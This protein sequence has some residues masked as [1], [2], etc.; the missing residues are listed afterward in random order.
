[1]TT[2][3][4]RLFSAARGGTA[5]VGYAAMVDLLLLLKKIP[6]CDLYWRQR[7]RRARYVRHVWT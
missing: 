5:V 1:M 3:S 2:L 6:R 7:W 4:Q